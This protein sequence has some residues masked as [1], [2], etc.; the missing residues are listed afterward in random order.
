[1]D[2]RELDHK[3]LAHLRITAG[4]RVVEDGETPSIVME[5]RGRCRTTIYPWWRPFEDGG[6]EALAA[7]IAAGPE[8][9]LREP[10]RH[11][12]RRWI[13]GKD[14]RQDG[15]EFGLWTRS[16]VAQRIAPRMGVTLGLTAVGKLLAQLETPPQKPLRRASERDPAAVQ[17]WLEEEYPACAPRPVNTGRASAS[18]LKRGLTRSRAWGAPA[19]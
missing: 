8:P 6:W 7:K 17:A 10:P 18:W 19:G 11:R 2:G 3:T 13:V 12:V 1:M 15:F 9:R 16:I 14:P 5:S 4:R